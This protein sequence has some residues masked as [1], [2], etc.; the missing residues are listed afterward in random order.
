MPTPPDAYRGSADWKVAQPTDELERGTWWR[1][2]R[3]PELDELESRVDTANQGLKAALARLQEARAQTRIARADFFPT[4]TTGASVQHYRNSL[5]A[6]THSPATPTVTSDLPLNVDLSYGADVWGRI[7]NSVAAARLGE[8]A[9][10]ADLGVL[11]LA[12]HAELASDYFVLRG[13]D[14]E[15]AILDQTVSDYARA[16]ALTQSLHSGGL[17]A[18]ADVDQAK[19]QLETARTRAAG[20]HLLRAQ[21]EHAIAVLLGESASSFHLEARPLP[22][23]VSPPRIDPGLPS[24]LLERRPDI[25]AA[26]RRVAAANAEIGVARAAYFPVFDL[27]AVAGFESTQASNWVTAP[28]RMWSFGPTAALTLFDAGRR[29]AQ[30]AEVRAGYDEQVAEYRSVV[31]T[32]YQEV[33][34]SLSALHDLEIESVSEAAA[35]QATESALQQTRYQYETGLVT[36]LQVVVTENAALEARLAAAD[37]QIHRMSASVLFVK[38]LGGGWDET[39]SPR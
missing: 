10:A 18:L 15:Q 1:L 11:S 22:I 2:Y 36:Y 13:A 20:T 32:A 16:L 4:V 37:I 31:L 23:D 35:V 25:A 29:H 5:Y 30:V 3:D 7:R 8:Q 27:L 34:D 26:E 28:A 9:S 6:P 21:T 24:A 12:T 14:M 38:A 39:S 17:A 19:A 33:E